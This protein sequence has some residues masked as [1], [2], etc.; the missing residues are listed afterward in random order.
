MFGYVAQFL[1][2]GDSPL[3]ERRAAALALDPTLLAELLGRGEGAG[4][5]RPARPG[6][7]R[8]HRGRA[9]AAG[10]RARLPR[11]RGRR[12]PAARARPAVRS[13]TIVR[14]AAR[15]RRPRDEIGAWLV[16]L[17]GARRLIRVRV[18][19]EE[20]W[21]AIEDAARLRD[22]L[23][24][25]LPVGVPQ[26]FLEPVPDP[27]GD[28]VAR[29]ART[30]GPFPAAD[31]RRAGGASGRPSSIDALRRLVAAGR[32]VE[33]ELLPDRERRRRTAS[34]SATPRCC[35]CCAAARW[36]PCAP[37]SSRSRRSSSRGSCRSGRASAAACAAREGLLRAVEQLAGAVVPASALETL[38]LPA[39]VADYR[40]A[41]LDEL[42]SAAR[43]S[44]A[45][46]G[47]C[48]AT[49]AGCPCTSPT[50]RHLTLAP[51]RGRRAH[52][53]RAGRRSTPWPAA[54]PTSS[55]PWPTPRR[56][57]GDDATLIADLWDLAWAGRVTN[58]TLAPL[59]AL[60]AGGRTAH[61][62]SRAGPRADAV[63]RSA[64]LAGRRSSGR[65][66]PGR[67]AA[68]TAPRPPTA[69][70]AGRG[71]LLPAAASPTRPCAPTP[72]PR[73]CSTATA[74]VTRGLGRRRGRRRR[75]RRASTACS[76]RPRRPAGC[77]AATSSRG[78][79]P[80]SSPRPARSTGSAPARA[81]AS[82]RR[83]PTTRPIAARWSSPPPTRPTPTAPR[84]RGRERGPTPRPTSRRA[85]PTAARAGRRGHQPGRKAGA[86]VVLVD[87]ELVL[88]VERGGKTLLS[89]TDDARAPA[90]RRRRAGARRARRRSG[91]AHRREGRRRRQVLGLGPPARATALA[92]AG[93]HATPRGLRLRR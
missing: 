77:G 26:A 14:P 10:A 35:G 90:G 52:R 86:L 48:P 66:R 11:R 60:L 19:G 92:A 23:G 58:D 18:A 91:P 36:P 3:A 39:R 34:T 15:A 84:S 65:R 4:A 31:R 79:V 16:E 32:V 50:P 27:L 53:R 7:G 78:S 51:R 85:G 21:A 9:A 93:F 43:C 37:R 83:R 28:L 47:R 73:C 72:P 62:R 12:R 22:A 29:Y 41:L 67:R 88:Y 38:V 2:E 70:A 81:T 1:Y 76:R 8:P 80:R 74:C 68:P 44:G 13:T 59:R 33:G 24:T 20:R 42:M 56:Q 64:R 30:H 61:K 40:P 45:A 54:A 17:E 75:V 49:T 5:A 82:A 89:W 71:S 55:A 87:G 25:P 6:G 69:P 63:C 57:H 46:T